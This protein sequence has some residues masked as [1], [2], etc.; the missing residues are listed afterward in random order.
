MTD[1][2]KLISDLKN[3]RQ[4]YAEGVMKVEHRD[5]TAMSTVEV[6]DRAIEYIE[7]GYL[8]EESEEHCLT[9]WGCLLA[10][11]SDYGIEIEGI[12]GKAGEHIVDDFMDLLIENGYAEER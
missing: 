2:E 8:E 10:I 7:R 11:L 4:A 6:L 12:A 1:T 5:I 9:P 3:H